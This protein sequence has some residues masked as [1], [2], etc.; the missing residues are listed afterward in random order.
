[1]T[2]IN[3]LIYFVK[4]DRY[5]ISECNCV[6]PEECDDEECDVRQYTSDIVA[7]LEKYRVEQTQGNRMNPIIKETSKIRITIEYKNKFLRWLL[8]RAK[9][10]IESVENSEVAE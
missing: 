3:K 10:T 5:C 8:G 4:N 9:I 6:P 2:D 1:M 7:I